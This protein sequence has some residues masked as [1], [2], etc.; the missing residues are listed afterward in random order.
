MI[1]GRLPPLNALR[2]FE[3]TAR[4]LSVKNAAAELCV[5]PGAVSQML[6]ALELHLGTKLFHRVN[7]GIFLTDVGQ[8]YLPPIRNAFRQMAEAT[9][10]VAVAA[11]TTLTVSVTPFFAASWLVPRLKRFQDTHPDADLRILTSSALADFSRDGVDVAV[12]HGIGRYPGLHS[13]RVLVVEIVPVAAPSL[14]A[15]KGRPI[16]AADLVH[17][18]HVHD[19]ERKGWHLWF[20]SQ[21][22]EETVAPRGPSF[23]DSGLLLKAV[24]SGQGA[25]LLPAAMLATE[26]EEGRLIRLADAALLDEFAYYLVYPEASHSRLKVAAFR[27]WI[28]KEAAH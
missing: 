18:P 16:C 8:S 17:W 27:S 24:L 19:A 4:H 6:K 15:E 21:G 2:A 9:Q 23:D 22:V 1:E 5:T 14:V 26:L 7:R 11:D 10:R 3:A 20:Q 13:D 25:G 12:R 28:L